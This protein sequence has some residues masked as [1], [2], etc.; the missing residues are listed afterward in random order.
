MG[1]AHGLVKGGSVLTGGLVERS[2]LLKTMSMAGSFGLVSGANQELHDQLAHGKTLSQLDYSKIAKSAFVHGGIDFLAGGPGG[3]QARFAAS[4]AA[5]NTPESIATKFRSGEQFRSPET[6]T[7]PSSRMTGSDLTLRLNADGTVSR[8]PV[9]REPVSRGKESATLREERDVDDANDGVLKRAGVDQTSKIDLWIPERD[10]RKISAEERI[11]LIQHVKTDLFKP[12]N[13]DVFAT[14][15]LDA[16]KTWNADLAPIKERQTAARNDW[17]AK[18]K[19]AQEKVF[20]S[21]RID[22]TPN[23]WQSSEIMR[24]KLAAHPDLLKIFNDYVVARDN[25]F[26]TH[27]VLRD[28][29]DTRV[30]QLET[31]VN[32]FADTQGLPRV[33]LKY[34]EDLGSAGAV[35]ESLTGT[36]RIL[37]AD[38]L[39]TNNTGRLVGKIYHELTHS[40]QDGL[41]VAWAAD[42][43]G[44][45]KTATSDQI[46]EMTSLLKEHAG[47]A[48]GPER[49]HK[50]LAQRDGTPLT[51]EQSQR[52]AELAEGFK[53]NKP[54][55]Q[56]YVESGDHFRITRRELRKLSDI[57]SAFLLIE[58]LGSRTGG[59][60]LSKHLFGTTELPAEI[61]ALD[62]Q[63]KQWLADADSVEW[64]DQ[65]IRVQMA[66]VLG[67]RLS[68][69]NRFRQA[70]YADYMRGTHEKEAWLVG[71]RAELRAAA[72]GATAKNPAKSTRPG[73]AM[74]IGG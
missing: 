71:E 51:A 13:I 48:P 55:G 69:I 9:A 15:I 1:A 44:V 60:A 70:K 27:R 5:L 39:D 49:M 72:F 54:M 64:P 41:V 53:Q 7:S 31:A 20:N 22:A 28:A 62:R 12:E 18:V 45:G 68:N 26:E 17:E 30:S 19:L 56:D 4:R 74:A 34:A 57:N 73:N 36:I 35:H 61:Q 47:F 59:A 11:E 65:Q 8:E 63:R 16:T 32:E 37:E 46:T 21:D 58:R 3:M 24:E 50:V 29:V 14:K 40:E 66:Q 6:L 23:D 43:I 67:A 33:T 10:I 2:P 38:V 42:R 25:Y 52:A